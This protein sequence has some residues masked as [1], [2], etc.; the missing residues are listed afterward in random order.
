MKTTSQHSPTRRGFLK[1]LLAAGA[2]PLIIP[3]RV[4]GADGQP[5]PDIYLDDKL[6]MNANGYAIWTRVVGEH[7][8]KLTRPGLPARP[9]VRGL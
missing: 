5:K 4:L 8:Q 3:N 1:T 7:L 9:T 2:A 6:H